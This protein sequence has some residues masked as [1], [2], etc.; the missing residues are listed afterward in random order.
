MVLWSIVSAS[1][2]W[3]KGRASFLVT[4]CLLGFMQGG[5]I[6]D[7][8]LYLSYF[9]TKNERESMI[10]FM[11]PISDIVFFSAPSVGLV[12]GLKLHVPSDWCFLGYWYPSSQRN[13]RPCRLAIPLLD[14][15]CLDSNSWALLIH[16][17]ASWS[18]SNKNVVQTQGLVLGTVSLPHPPLL[19]MVY[20]CARKLQGRSYHG[21]PCI[22]R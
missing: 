14:R 5:F 6:P 22:A 21:Q 20:L 1:Q 4:R 2:F 10:T 3:L 18:H 12:L 7:V 8:I 17:Y 19:L 11:S 16:S 15:R 13:W 9:Y